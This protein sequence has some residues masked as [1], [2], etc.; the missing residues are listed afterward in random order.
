MKKIYI[1]AG[2]KG[3][4]GKSTAAIY[5]SNA[6]SERK[7]PHINID[8]N[9]CNETF[10]RF[11]GDEVKVVD[12]TKPEAIEEIEKI[13]NTSGVNDFV[14]DLPAGAR[15]KTILLV[16]KLIAKKKEDAEFY[17]IG[18]IT[19]DVDSVLSFLYWAGCLKKQVNYIVAFCEF[20]G[21]D[22]SYYEENAVD[23]ERMAHPKKLTIPRLH[24]VYQCP[25]NHI[26]TCLGEYLQGKTFIDDIN[27]NGRVPQTRLY[28]FYK[29]IITQITEI[30]E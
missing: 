14:I 1:I 15:G 20:N 23:F 24:E 3:G 18:C 7:R 6:L 27:F 29:N 25:L 9:K 2:T 8:C 21:K 28:R 4:V 13:I 10:K 30:I 26:D 12:L 19:L 5:F 16:E 17:L 22:F 11:L